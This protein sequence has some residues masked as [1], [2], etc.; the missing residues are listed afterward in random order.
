MLHEFLMKRSTVEV[1]KACLQRVCMLCNLRHGSCQKQ[2]LVVDVGHLMAGFMFVYKPKSMF[3][4]MGSFENALQQSAE[5]VLNS[6]HDI[7][8]ST[9]EKKAFSGAPSTLTKK[10]QGILRDYLGCLDA[11]RQAPRSSSEIHE[12]QFNTE[13][14]AHELLLDPRFQIDEGSS[15]FDALREETRR[16][17]E[18][19]FSA[20]RVLC[21]LASMRSGMMQLATSV[22]LKEIIAGIMDMDSLQAAMQSENLFRPIKDSLCVMSAIYDIVLQ[23]LPPHR[24][25][26]AKTEWSCLVEE[27]QQDSERFWQQAT[28]LAGKWVM[29]MR[30]E[31]SNAHLRR[32]ANTVKDYGIVYE[33]SRFQRRLRAGTITLHHTEGLILSLMRREVS[34]RRLSLEDLIQRRPESIVHLHTRAL[35]ETALL[36][37][38]QPLPETLH[39]DRAR[40]HALHAELTLIVQGASLLATV[41]SAFPQDTSVWDAA[42][43]CVAEARDAKAM[44]QA[45]AAR[46]PFSS[47]EHRLNECVSPSDS[48][49]KV[50]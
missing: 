1:S 15:L 30:I 10:F 2:V 26:E 50:M 44:V 19:P 9:L 27:K 37:E 17:C 6:W 16:L 35:I 23:M 21:V 12:K 43:E 32:V 22:T 24:Q 11:W 8:R 33:R 49:Y 28:L 36:P 48:V 41:R 7:V 40:I 47:L 45:L 3:T 18:E 46:R 14:L 25:Q 29:R 42:K 38:H 20:D 5:Q 39:L 31:S 34:R 13:Q 4:S